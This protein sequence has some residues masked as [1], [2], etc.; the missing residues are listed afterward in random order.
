[1]VVAEQKIDRRKYARL[2]AQ[3]VPAVIKT[4]E[5]NERMLGEIEQL[6]DKGE[7]MTPE[8][9]TLL[10]LMSRLVEDFESEAYPVA[11]ATPH[12][13][14]RHLLESNDLKQADLVPIFGSR[15]YT[16]DIVNGKRGISKEHA[17]ALGEFFHVSPSLF[18]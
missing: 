5:E 17:K 6:I 16:S 13:V 4:E 1:M 15:G 9:V 8:E 7:G 10:E 11:D 12:Q 3:T 14:L 2:L 18:I